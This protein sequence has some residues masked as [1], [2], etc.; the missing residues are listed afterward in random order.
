MCLAYYQIKQFYNVIQKA[1]WVTLFTIIVIGCS[2]PKHVDETT[3]DWKFQ[4]QREE[5]APAYWVDENILFDGKSTLALSGNGKSY[6]NG[7]WSYTYD[8]AP[9]KYYEFTAYFKSQYVHQLNRSILAQITWLSSNGEQVNFIGFPATLAK[10]T[11]DGWYIIQQ[12]YQ[13]PKGAAKAR[14][15]LILRWAAGGTVFFGGMSFKETKAIEPRM[16]RLAA[17]HHRPENTNS[18]QENLDEF[19]QY[20]EKAGKQKADI[21]CLSEGITI[22]GTAK[23]YMEV[24]EPIPGPTTKFLGKL[25]KKYSMYIVAGILEKTESLVYNTS[26]LIDRNGEV[27]GKY[28]KASLPCE[29]IDAGLTPGESFPVFDTDFGKIGMLICWDLH[30]PESARMLALQGA[31]IIFFPNWDSDVVI[32]KARAIENQVYLVSS[33]YTDTMKTGV[34]DKNGKLL[35]EG[36]KENPIAIVEVDLN[37]ENIWP[38]VGN[39]KNRIQHELPSSKAIK[40]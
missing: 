34:F 12:S 11:E 2:N 6:A 4:S 15:N 37:Q 23:T 38:W 7:S 29:E 19:K 9:N 25:A 28:R 39:F 24:S 16:V 40:Y 33:T 26:V 8:A 36:T 35:V 30:F 20:I 31:E 3:T 27:A 17:I 22:V 10:Q 1:R 32:T 18:S 5:L 14:I 21:V 13:V